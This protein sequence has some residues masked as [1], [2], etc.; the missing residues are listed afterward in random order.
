MMI[1]YFPFWFAG[2]IC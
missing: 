1:D 2:C